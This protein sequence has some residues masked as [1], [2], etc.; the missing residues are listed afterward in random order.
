[1]VKEEKLK[2]REGLELESLLFPSPQADPAG[3]KPHSH[4][5]TTS[6]LCVCVCVCLEKPTFI[7]CLCDCIDVNGVCVGLSYI[8]NVSACTVFLCMCEFN[9]CVHVSLW[10]YCAAVR[11]CVPV[12]VCVRMCVCKW[13]FL[14][15]VVKQV[16]ATLCACLYV[17][18]CAPHCFCVWSCYIKL[19]MCCDSGCLCVTLPVCVSLCVR[20]TLW[21][22]NL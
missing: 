17:C 16:C 4:V 21:L 5:D 1:M 18:V 19:R 2:E 11:L 8:Y 9:V 6:F 7:V 20:Q 14:I 22:Q 13:V 12:C 15:N 10:I 3:L